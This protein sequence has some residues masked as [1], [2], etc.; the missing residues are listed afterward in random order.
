MVAPE[1]PFSTTG[2]KRGKIEILPGEPLRFIEEERPATVTEESDIEINKTQSNARIVGATIK[3]YR[4]ATKVLL[5][6]KYTDILEYVS[7]H[8]REPCI[9]TVLCCN[10]GILIRYDA[11]DVDQPK[12]L[13]ITIDAT[14]EVVAP[15]FSDSLIHFPTDPALYD[16]GPGVIQLELAKFDLV[17]GEVKPPISMMRPLIYVSSTMLETQAVLPP[18]HRPMP[19]ISMTNELEVNFSGVVLPAEKELA[20]Q[21]VA[22]SQEF[23]TRG[24]MSLKV[25]WRAIE[26][27]PCFDFAYWKPEYAPL[28]AEVDLLAAVARRQLR[29]AHFTALD[30]NLAARKKFARLIAELEAL[31]DGPEEPVHQFLKANTC[32]LSPTHMVCWSKLPFGERFSDFVFREPGGDYLLVEI[33]SPLRELFRKDG[34]QR[35]ELTHAFNQILDWRVYIENN[36]SSVR[37][38]LGLSGISS[39]PKSLI[40]IGR[41]STLSEENRLKLTTLQNQIPNLRILTYDD[42]IL[43]TKSVAEN[44]FGPLDFVTSNGEIYFTKSNN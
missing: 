29:D 23:V 5:T 16:P 31:L 7:S 32:L 4:E 9:T 6:S 25:G 11:A 36:L 44:L 22:K 18:P 20:P 28:W 27:Y 35:Q 10:D 17:S 33:E 13:S 12:V 41:S 24:T 37:E 2:F 39:N 30:P 43:H 3:A 38:D 42:L 19:L 34:Q 1:K 15:Q 40:V 14:L 8:L 21:V 26:I